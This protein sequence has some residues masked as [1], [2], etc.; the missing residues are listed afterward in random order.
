MVYNRRADA[1]HTLRRPFRRLCVDELLRSKTAPSR[2]RPADRGSLRGFQILRFRAK[3][4]VA[5]DNVP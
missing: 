2:G 3:D 5:R 1:E 4:F